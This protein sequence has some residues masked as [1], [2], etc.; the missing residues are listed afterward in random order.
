LKQFNKKEFLTLP[1]KFKDQ[2][3]YLISDVC[4]MTGVSRSTLWRWTKSGILQDAAKRDRRGWRLFTAAD[5]VK[6]DDEAHRIK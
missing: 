2:E 6:I 5:V 4:R 3:F 1:V